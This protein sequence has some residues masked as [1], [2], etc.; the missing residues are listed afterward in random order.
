MCTPGL[1]RFYLE[2]H[3]E[4]DIEK[5]NSVEQ[6]TGHQYTLQRLRESRESCAALSYS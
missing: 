3:H 2:T 5:W 4:K 6:T 1:R